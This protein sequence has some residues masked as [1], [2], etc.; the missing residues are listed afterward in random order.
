MN[1]HCSY[2]N[3][4][5]Q[6]VRSEFRVMRMSGAAWAFHY[7]RL[8][9]LIPACVSTFSQKPVE[10]WLNNNVASFSSFFV[11]FFHWNDTFLHLAL[12]HSINLKEKQ[13]W[14]Y[15]WWVIRTK[16]FNCNYYK[17][18][19]SSW[20]LFLLKQ[21]AHVSWFSAAPFTP[22]SFV[23]KC[24]FLILH[25]AHLAVNNCGPFL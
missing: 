13:D 23:L 6:Y 17:C 9:F 10:L 8:V 11:L 7:V 14:S 16:N 12:K 24:S 1:V 5:L 3:M 15:N 25:L 2:W 19:F 20:H 4:G 18:V 22:I 21:R